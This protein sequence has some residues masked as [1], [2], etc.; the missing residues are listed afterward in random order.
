MTDLQEHI[1]N[2]LEEEIILLTHIKYNDD[3]NREDYKDV[4]KEF[5]QWLVQQFE[6]K[7]K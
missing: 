4:G 5:I 3:V 2:I 1:L 6:N 7:K